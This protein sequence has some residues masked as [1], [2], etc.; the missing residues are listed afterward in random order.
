MGLAGPISYHGSE[1]IPALVGEAMTSRD[2]A[3]IASLATSPRP[4]WPTRCAVIVTQTDQDPPTAKRVG[5]LPPRKNCIV[6]RVMPI[7]AAGAVSRQCLPEHSRVFGL[8][9]C[10]YQRQL[11]FQL[12]ACLTHLWRRMA[13]IL[14]AN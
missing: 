14:A 11:A 2:H 3:R 5:R 4:D 13:E 6:L 12:F 8:R 10:L 1:Y 9:S 7:R